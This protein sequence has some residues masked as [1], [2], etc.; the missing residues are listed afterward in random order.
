[1]SAMAAAQQNRSPLLVL[2]AALPRC[3][4]GMGSLQEIDHVPFVAPL[5]KFAATAPLGRDRRRLV[6][7][8]LRATVDAPSGVGVRRL[9]DGPRVLRCRRM[10]GA[11]RAFRRAGAPGR[12][13]RR[14]RPRRRPCW[15]CARPVIMAGANVWWGRAE[16]AMLRL[17]EAAADPR[18]DERHGPRHV[19]PTMSWRSRGP[20]QRAERGRR[21][22][23][24]RRADGLPAGLRQLFGDDAPASWRIVAEPDA[25]HPR[26]VAVGSTA[27]GQRPSRSL[28]RLRRKPIPPGSGSRELRAAETAARDPRQAELADDRARLPVRVYGELAP[29]LDRDA[30]VVDRRRRLR[31]LR[32]PGD[33]QLS[34]R[35]RLDPGPFGCLGL[36]PGYALAAKLARPDRQVVLLHG[37]GAFGFSGHGVRHAVRHGIP[38][39]AVIGNN[40]I[41]ALEKHPME[42]LF[43]YAVVAELRPGHALRRGG[44]GARRLR[45]TGVHAGRARARAAPGLR[46]RPARRRQ[47]AHRPGVAYPR[48]SNLWVA[49]NWGPRVQGRTEVRAAPTIHWLTRTLGPTKA[50]A[51]PATSRPTVNVWHALPRPTIHAS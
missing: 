4:G 43:G 11:R 34:A 35:L 32:G 16:P 5:A 39:V 12:R 27:T 46:Q 36:G 10:S 23:G 40:G 44:R 25:T 26:P 33:R 50:S 6:D 47:R 31:F 9:P 20:R 48:R 51:R 14:A 1:M 28:G 17:A 2:G 18:A 42:A 24:G 37:D 29:L 38:V 21:C 22:A 19:P 15:R 49:L 3:A 13:R 30:I 41:W 45:R 8:A 7:E